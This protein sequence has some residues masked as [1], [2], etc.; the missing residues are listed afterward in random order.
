M[1]LIKRPPI[2]D[3][4]GQKIASAIRS[5]SQNILTIRDNSA[6]HN[7]I[8]RG[9]ALGNEITS[10]QKQAIKN[11][12]FE[13]LFI[14]DYWTINGVNWRI[15]HFNYWLGTGDDDNI[16]TSNHIVI[17]P[18]TNLATAKMNSSNSTAGGYLGSGLYTG[19]NLDETGNTGLSTAKATFVNAFGQK[20]LLKHRELFSNAVTNGTVSGTIWVDSI[21]DL[22]SERMVYGTPVWGKSGYEAGIDKTILALFDLNPEFIQKQRSWYWLRPV[23]SAAGFCRVGTYGY[24]VN[25]GASDSVGVRPAAAIYFDDVE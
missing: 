9:E 21:V 20:H 12:T 8:F 19:I 17:V 13:N 15:A 5:S 7:S 23:G 6:Y 3:S 24:A 10:A 2:L 1:S 25:G 22:M 14:G 18:D 4:T 16:C 11:G